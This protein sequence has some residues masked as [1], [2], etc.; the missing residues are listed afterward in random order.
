M[1]THECVILVLCSQL[2]GCTFSLLRE[3]CDTEVSLDS[4]VALGQSSSADWAAVAVGGLSTCGLRTDGSTACWGRLDDEGTGL[5]VF[6]GY[7]HGCVLDDTGTARCFGRDDA[8]QAS[9]PAVRFSR[10]AL[11]GAHSCGE[12][13]GG[14]VVCWG[15]ED[16]AQTT[17]PVL[18]GVQELAAGWRHSCAVEADGAVVCWGDDSAGQSSPPALSAA[19]LALG[20]A[21]SCALDGEGRVQCWGEALVGG[22]SGG[23]HTGLALGADFACVLDEQG[24]VACWGAN[25]V[26]QLDAPTGT[27]WAGIDADAVGRHACAHREGQLVCWGADEQGQAS[28]P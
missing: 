7:D 3:T 22:P 28:P 8:G 4:G 11:G 5:S 24:A 18:D 21:R 13:V 6:A 15:R 26:G 23:G 16:E 2:A 17:V 9:P 27:G 14:A 12:E 20:Q 25:D 1:N 10:L 19:Q